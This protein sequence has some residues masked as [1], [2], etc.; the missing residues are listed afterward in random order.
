MDKIVFNN[1]AYWR[2]LIVLII[3]SGCLPSDIPSSKNISETVNANCPLYENCVTEGDAR[4]GGGTSLPPTVEIRHLIEPNLSTD[5]TYSTGTGQSSGG[6]YLRKITLPKNFAG[7]LYLAGINIGS[8]SSRFVKVRFKFG[9]NHEPVV[10]PATVAQAPGITPQTSINVLVMD[11]RSEPFRNIRLPYDLYDYNEYDLNIDGTFANGVEPTQDN[12]NSGLFCRGLKIEDDPTFQGLG[13]CGDQPEEECLYAYAKVID[14]GLIKVSGNT[15]VPLTPS[16]PQ[17][18]SVSGSDYY[19]DNMSSKLLKPLTDTI[20]SSGNNLAPVPFSSAGANSTLINFTDWSPVSILGSNYYY[21]GPYR[22]LNRNNWEFDFPFSKLDGKKRLFREDSWIY[23]SNYSSDPLP[24][25]NLSTP[26][27]DRLYYNSYLFP[28][29]TKLKLAANIS[30]LASSSPDGIRTEKIL[31]TAGETEWMDGANAR[32]QSRNYDLEH[33]GSCNVSATIE[34]IAKD[35]NNIDYVIA[36]SKEVK[37]QLVRPTQHR[38]D[39]AD[40]VLYTNF[41]SCNGSSGCGDSECC[42]NN[43]CWDQSLVSQCLDSSSNQGNKIVGES[44]F[45]DLEC[46][47]LCCNKTTGQCAPHNTTLNPAVLCSKPVGDFCISKEWCQKSTVIKCYIIK[48]G[49][50]PLGNITC[51]QQC[52]NVQEFGDCKNGTCVPPVQETIPTFDPNDPNACNNA[53]TAPNF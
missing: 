37:I 33:I 18:K 45:S 49:T 42:L 13:S 15:K 7:R 26:E 1:R 5:P 36:Q 24:D 39:I 20:P 35:D 21:R 14:Q 16:F 23:Y 46:S 22:I 12:R 32:A 51:R 25:D 41:K 3:A 2:L 6:S 19:T 43:R 10:I 30:H 28:L 31:S 11:L 48:T 9:L 47:S 34:I 44:C 38:T 8:L 40:E 52:Y 50:D 27:Q 4:I 17:V 29:A 53:I